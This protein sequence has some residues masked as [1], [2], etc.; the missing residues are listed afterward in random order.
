[1]PCTDGRAIKYS[2]TGWQQVAN[3]EIKKAP[4]QRHYYQPAKSLKM[5][6][7]ALTQLKKIAIARCID[8][9]SA[10]INSLVLEK[11]CIT[12]KFALQ[13]HESTDTSG[14]SQL[15]ANVRFVD[16]D[17]TRENF[18]FCKALPKQTTGDEVFQ[19]A[20]E[21]LEEEVLKWKNPVEMP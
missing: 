17:A 5:R 12:A 3:D 11:I 1:M 15:L 6:C 18:L 14:H 19:V 20:S 21:Y 7:L 13:F 9:M 8:D 4:W 10:D 2:Y 16:R